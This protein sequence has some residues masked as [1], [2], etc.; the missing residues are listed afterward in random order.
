MS[1]QYVSISEYILT[2]NDHFNKNQPQ[3]FFKTTHKYD[4]FAEKGIRI[5]KWVTIEELLKQ[6]LA[7][8]INFF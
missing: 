6:N 2:D 7:N 8:G 1:Q 3:V 4:D 5:P